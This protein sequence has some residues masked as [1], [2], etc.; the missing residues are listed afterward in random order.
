MVLKPELVGAIPV[1]GNSVLMSGV[2]CV[3][4]APFATFLGESSNPETA[5]ALRKDASTFVNF[6]AIST[7]SA[8]GQICRY[9]QPRLKASLAECSTPDNL[10]NLAL[11]RLAGNHQT[12][13]MRKNGKVL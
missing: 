12:M 1:S 10:A 4:I 5:R 6:C 13:T 7:K 9:V 8:A 3:D 2:E 11:V